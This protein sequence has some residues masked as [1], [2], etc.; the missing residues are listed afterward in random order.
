[1]LRS[2]VTVA[3]Y[4]FAALVLLDGTA[5]AQQPPASTDGKDAEARSLFEA[6][7]TAY[8]EGRYENAFDYFK[9][10]Y[11]L[12]ARPKLLF[13]IGQTADRLR[14]DQEALGAFEAY[15]R[16]VPDA[17]NRSQVENRVQAL[18]SVVKSGRTKGGE[19]A[20]Q[21]PLAPEAAAVASTAERGKAG[22]ASQGPA[23]YAIGSN[24]E[25][26]DK[27]GGLLSKWWFWT[28][29]GVVVTG[30]VVGVAIAASGGGQKQEG[31]LATET[32]IVVTALRE[33]P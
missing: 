32:G 33:A 21:K 14:R 22:P 18:R 2:T 16:Q 27:G 24:P 17:P 11:Q 29:A 23:G 15:L 4:V 30:I 25:R 8:A 28:A 10:S 12:S 19:E 6:G 26:R 3:L 5:R 13:N 7:S 31:P 9:R 1:M 20:G